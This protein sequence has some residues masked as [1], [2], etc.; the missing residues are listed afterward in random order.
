MTSKS[1]VDT[2]L[3]TGKVLHPV[4]ESGSINNKMMK[5]FNLPLFLALAL[6]KEKR[7]R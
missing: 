2:F 7:R 6:E 4:A 1:E 5:I 3:E